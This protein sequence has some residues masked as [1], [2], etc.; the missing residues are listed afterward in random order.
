MKSR[1]YTMETFFSDKLKELRKLYNLKQDEFGKKIGLTKAQISSYERGVSVP[2]LDFFVRIAQV[3]NV[4]IEQLI[5][6][7]MRSPFYSRLVLSGGSRTF[8]YI[9]DNERKEPFIG[10]AGVIPMSANDHIRNFN[11][12]SIPE[13]AINFLLLESDL[14]GD[15]YVSQ[16]FE[17]R[18]E[19]L[20]ILDDKKIF[21]VEKLP[22]DIDQQIE[23]YPLLIELYLILE[24]ASWLQSPI[25][26]PTNGKNILA[27][28]LNND[29]IVRLFI[30]SRAT[31]CKLYAYYSPLLER[32]I[33]AWFSIDEDTRLNIAR[34]NYF[35]WYMD[36]TEYEDKEMEEII[37]SR[38][39][40][41][42]MYTP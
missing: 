5:D 42:D 28:K 22:A 20:P 33:K 18:F 35:Q 25:S 17:S 31:G 27:L 36:M 10:K 38:E 30:S 2:N 19:S 40:F 7:P 26:W 34:E 6:L 8:R 15:G 23:G 41:K 1:G 9:L 3:F 13:I 39:Q 11:F 29:R 12:H 16:F 37:K 14:G 4:P 21:S 24:Q 32:N